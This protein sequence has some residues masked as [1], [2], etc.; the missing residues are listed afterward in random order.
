M[1]TKKK[2][3]ARMLIILECTECILNDKKG[4]SRYHTTKNR[5]N[6]PEKLEIFKHCPYC[7]KHT[8]H[9]EIK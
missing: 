7:N 8:K 5:R 1:K 9:K 4:V 2:K 3:S 6:T